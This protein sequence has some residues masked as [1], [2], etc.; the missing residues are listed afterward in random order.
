MG[1][2]GTYGMSEQDR[3]DGQEDEGTYSRSV[4]GLE[5][6]RTDRG[7]TSQI[8][9]DGRWT[10]KSRTALNRVKNATDLIALNEALIL[11]LQTIVKKRHMDM[12]TVL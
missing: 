5:A 3:G 6:I 2:D 4:D 11:S 8:T 10:Q 12:R 7:Q 1:I 9:R